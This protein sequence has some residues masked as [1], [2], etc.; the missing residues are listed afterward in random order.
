MVTISKMNGMKV[1]TVDAFTLGEIDGAV[2]DTDQWKI[3]HLHVDLT[4]ESLRELG[5]KKPFLGTIKI[6]LPVNVIGKFGDVITLKS[7]L[8]ELR[9]IPECKEKK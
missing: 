1:I 3:T 6:C 5:L 7:S 8:Q 2:A 4:E 9:N